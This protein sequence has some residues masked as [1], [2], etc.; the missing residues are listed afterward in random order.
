MEELCKLS[1][2]GVFKVESICLF[3]PD[4]LCLINR[5]WVGRV[6]IYRIPLFSNSGPAITLSLS[7]CVGVC[8]SVRERVSERNS[9][10]VCEGLCES[11]E[12]S[13]RV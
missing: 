4:D 3:C 5:P 11:V 12:E 7:R 10:R 6:I 1:N 8:V 13:A 9:V 2:K